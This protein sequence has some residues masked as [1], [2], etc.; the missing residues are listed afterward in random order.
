MRVSR[1]LS[2][3][4]LGAIAY[5]LHELRRESSSHRSG[6][7]TVIVL[8]ILL[9][10]ENLEH[11]EF[12]DHGPRP[13]ETLVDA[14]GRAVEELVQRQGEPVWKGAR[15]TRRSSSARTLVDGLR[16]DGGVLHL[17][18][19]RHGVRVVV[20]EVH[21]RRRRHEGDVEIRG[22]D[23]LGGNTGQRVV[24]GADRCSRAIAT[25]IIASIA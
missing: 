13:A 1:R 24:A 20:V 2:A 7:T 16:S 15:G 22:V 25:I 17:R 8:I 12:A 19:G 3:Y 21:G 14:R 18:G 11:V 9:I 5:D 6:V 23:G 4:S 10:E